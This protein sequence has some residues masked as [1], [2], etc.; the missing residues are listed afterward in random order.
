MSESIDKEAQ[1]LASGRFN[2]QNTID[3]L[4]KIERT[5]VCSIALTRDLNR[6]DVY[7]FNQSTSL[8]FMDS[9]Q[10]DETKF[11][12]QIK[13]LHRAAKSICDI[14]QVN[15][16]GTIKWSK[17][18][19]T[20]AVQDANMFSVLAMMGDRRELNGEIRRTLGLTDIEHPLIEL[21][22]IALSVNRLKNVLELIKKKDPIWAWKDL[23]K[24]E[25]PSS[26]RELCNNLMH[27]HL[28]P[29]YESHFGKKL[30][31]VTPRDSHEM[32]NSKE[33]EGNGIQFLKWT[34]AKFNFSYSPTTI[35]D[36]FYNKG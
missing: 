16:D 23:K 29:I 32:G 14:F 31:I 21:Q 12:E 25:S 11:H 18:K 20:K 28:A 30:T 7:S 5:D 22:N 17:G 34:L 35:R 13:T 1:L 10:A 8:M 27:A 6:V 24:P 33:P 2:E 4:N 26:E 19:K 9:I 36:Y 3:F 15:T